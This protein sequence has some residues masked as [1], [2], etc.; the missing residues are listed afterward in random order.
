MI[1]RLLPPR[2]GCSPSLVKTSLLP[3]AREELQ[4]LRGTL[5]YGAVNVANGYTLFGVVSGDSAETYSVPVA[6]GM[7]QWSVRKESAARIILDRPDPA[8]A[9]ASGRTEISFT[10]WAPMG[11]GYPI[12]PLWIDSRRGKVRR[13]VIGPIKGGLTRAHWTG[14]C[15]APPWTACPRCRRSWPRGT[16][17]PCLGRDRSIAD[18]QAS[19]RQRAAT[20][21]RRMRAA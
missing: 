10:T 18:T 19:V 21:E 2:D 20:R 1:C 8:N 14:A 9:L 6:R 3:H 4:G 15:A 12:T 16:R 13:D 7:Q 11:S 5:R 17:S